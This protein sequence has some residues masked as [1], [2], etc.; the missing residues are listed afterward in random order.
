M[1]TLQAISWGAR[2]PPKETKVSHIISNI[3][4]RYM[5]WMEQA[6]WP[7]YMP[8]TDHMADTSPRKLTSK[9]D[10]ASSI[11][12]FGSPANFGNMAQGPT[13]AQDV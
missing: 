13:E 2:T 3:P 5:A 4:Y 7:L 12:K 11:L 10:F 1:S 6:E 9:P 8:F